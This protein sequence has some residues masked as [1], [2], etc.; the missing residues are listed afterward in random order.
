MNYR[1]V[2]ACAGTTAEG[3]PIKATQLNK[4]VDL[5]SCCRA[6][7]K[8]SVSGGIAQ[9]GQSK[10]SQGGFEARVCLL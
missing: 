3:R 9:A 7:R 6:L 10:C 2:S 1:E 5:L 8:R 4:R